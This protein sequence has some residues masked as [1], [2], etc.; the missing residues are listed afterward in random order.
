MD[1]YNNNESSDGQ[2]IE[3]EDQYERP[4]GYY[5]Q[6]KTPKIIELT[7]QYSGGIIKDEKQA[8]YVLLI[9]SVLIIVVSLATL[10][11]GES[12]PN[13]PPPANYPPLQNR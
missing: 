9:I 4:S 5:S 1:S 11:K 6:R 8:S 10:F 12:V 7:I 2:K 13:I 3:F